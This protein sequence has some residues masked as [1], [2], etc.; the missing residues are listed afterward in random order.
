MKRRLVSL[1]ALILI[2]PRQ[3]KIVFIP[4]PCYQRSATIKV[5]APVMEIEPQSFLDTDPHTMHYSPR[6][7]LH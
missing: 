6:P 5:L 4:V 2:P 1:L 7:R 3:L